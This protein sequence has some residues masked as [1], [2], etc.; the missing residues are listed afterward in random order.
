[1]N[2]PDD[3]ILAVGLV[4]GESVDLSYVRQPFA[5]ESDFGVT[6]VNYKLAEL[7]QRGKSPC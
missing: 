2:K 4:N 1:M 5:R 3:F 7:L 6:S